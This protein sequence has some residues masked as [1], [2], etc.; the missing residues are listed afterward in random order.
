MDNDVINLAKAIRQKESGGNFNAVG[1]AGTSKGGYQ[2][3]P[4][5]WKEHS[6]KILGKENAEMTPDNQNAVAYG[7]IKT[8]KDKGLNP[9]QIAAKWNSGQS[10]GWENKIGTTTINGQKIKY[11]VPEYVKEV[12]SIYQTLKQQTTKPEIVPTA[13]EISDQASADK[14]GATF[15]AKIG[16]G[17]FSAAAKTVGNVPRSA[18]NFAK[19]ALDIINPVST[20]N[21]IKEI[22]SGTKEVGIGNVLKEVPKT[23]Y[24][25]LV[26]EAARSLIKGDTEE[27]QRAVTNDPFGQIAPFL[28][29]AKGG[30]KVADRIATKSDMAKFAEKPFGRDIPKPSTKFDTAL[31]T[32]MKKT[33]E[34]VTKP[35]GFVAEKVGGG[36]ASATRAGIAQVTGLNKETVPQIIKKPE[37]FTKKSMAETDRS[38]LGRQVQSELGK[39]AEEKS[40]T[41]KSYEPIKAMKT[42][43]KVDS[44]FLDDTITETT[45]LKIKKGQLVADTTSKIRD[46]GDV[47]ALQKVYDLWGKAF[48][49]GE[50]TTNEY[51]NLREDLAKAARFEKDI[52]VRKEV[53]ILSGKIRAKLNQAYRPQIEGLEKLDATMSE[54]IAQYKELARGLVDKEG[55]ITDAGMAKIANL[56]KNKPN[57]AVQLERIVPGITEQVKN[58]QAIVDIERASG[59]KVG[60]YTKGAIVG[61]GLAFGGPI[62]AVINLILTSPQMAVPILRQYGLLKNST[63]VKAVMQALKEGGHKLNNPTELAPYLNKDVKKV[64]PSSFGK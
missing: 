26:P 2:W 61:G 18:F 38:S 27:A 45:G 44:N 17:A 19:G 32:G 29:L 49:K 20:I 46:V 33:S 48:K 54:Q 31:E 41:G 40:A 42:K 35:A 8:W 15:G 12:T 51:L 58:L 4:N 28:F 22:V 23:A 34:L 55:N 52:G 25:S 57:L 5:T 37:A 36:I 30:A 56:S 10:E 60:T 7:M 1:D 21:K 6:K 63:A 3:Q 64:I 62:Q 39:L 9:A 59:I 14:Y 13:S 47:R 50:L 16:E 24:E 11:N 43:V 53:Q